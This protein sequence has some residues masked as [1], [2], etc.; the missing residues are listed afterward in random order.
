MARLI[1]RGTARDGALRLFGGAVAKPGSG[2]ATRNRGAGGVL[3]F[4]DGKLDFAAGGIS[5]LMFSRRIRVPGTQAIRRRLRTR[6]SASG[7]KATTKAISDQPGSEMPR[8][9]G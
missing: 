5:Q 9:G 1:L 4:D 2:L 8:I 7:T 3:V 6:L